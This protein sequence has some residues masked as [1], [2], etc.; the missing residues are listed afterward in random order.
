MMRRRG[1]MIAASM[2]LCLCLY[3]VMLVVTLP[4]LSS[5]A[6]GLTPLD[7]RSGGYTAGEARALFEALGEHGRA[8]Y[9][10]P[11][12]LIDSA[13]P[14][15]VAVAFGLAL[16][17]LMPRWRWVAFLPAV[18]AGIDYAENL[19]TFSLLRSYPALPESLIQVGSTLTVLKTVA[20]SCCYVL[21]LAAVAAW[22]WRRARRR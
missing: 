18:A 9:L 5:L 14:A 4:H 13:F 16:R 20:Y 15:S 10:R 6:G 1:W 8:Y 2:A 7:M 17:A 22:G 21:T 11:Q 3:V 19:N 12:L